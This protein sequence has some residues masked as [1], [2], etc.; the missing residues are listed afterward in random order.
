MAIEDDIQEIAESIPEL[1]SHGSLDDEAKTKQYLILPFIRALGYNDARPSEVV[2]EYTAD[3]G[4]GWKVDYAL[5]S[6]GQPAIII[7]C[8]KFGENLDAHLTQLGRYFPFTKAQFAVLT[9]GTIYRFFTE[10]RS[11]RMIDPTPFLELNLERLDP[12][13]L[14]QLEKFKIG[15]DVNETVKTASRLRQINGMKE[16]LRQQYINP[17]DDFVSWL[18]GRVYSGRMTQGARDELRELAQRAFNDFVNDRIGETLKLAQS[19][20]GQMPSG[21]SEPPQPDDGVADAGARRVVTTA[22]EWEAFAIV[23]AILHDTVSADRVFIRDTVQ[24]CAIVLDDNRRR[25]LCR[26]RLDGI[27]KQIGLFDGSR[28]QGGSGPASRKDSRYRLLG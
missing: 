20:I 11:D 9:N 6:D 24:Y 3:F 10:S 14:R 4:Q 15:F 21:E 13:S 22:Q 1:R 2:P 7:E 28:E 12:E 19:S 27:P 5:M 16:V 17:E 23:K 25:P 26:L 8:K 18:G